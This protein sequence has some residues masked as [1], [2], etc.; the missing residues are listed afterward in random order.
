[1]GFNVVELCVNYAEAIFLDIG[2]NRDFERLCD[3]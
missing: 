3:M 1:M 2:R